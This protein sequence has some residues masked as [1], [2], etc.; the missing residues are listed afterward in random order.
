[1][2]HLCSHYQNLPPSNKLCLLSLRMKIDAV[3][4]EARRSPKT[5][6][7]FGGTCNDGRIPLTLMLFPSNVFVL[8]YTVLVSYP[9]D[10]KV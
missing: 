1:M 10:P 6:M 7:R 5:L 3:K 2:D 9:F 8:L 4:A